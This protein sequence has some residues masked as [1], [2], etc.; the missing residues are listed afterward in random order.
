MD[1]VVVDVLAKYGMLLSRYWGAKLG[2]SL[3]LNMTYAMIP[4]FGGHFT[5][6][7]R[8]TRL[9]YTVSDPHNPNNYPVY[10]EDKDLGNCILSIDDGFD[11]CIEESCT[12]ESCT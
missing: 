6:L 8:E 5:H 10:V 12:E 2:G 11:E 7:Y 4:I 9:A 1:V 3:Q